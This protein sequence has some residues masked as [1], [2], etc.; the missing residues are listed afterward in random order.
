MFRRRMP[1]FKNCIAFAWCI[2]NSNRNTVTYANS[3]GQKVD[4]TM[5]RASYSPDAYTYP[6]KER[7]IAKK[8][9]EY[10]E[11]EDRAEWPKWIV[12]A[13]RKASK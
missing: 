4:E 2:I 12:P 10:E 9:E 11:V 5:P 3:Y 7:V 6:I 1:E 8:M 13:K